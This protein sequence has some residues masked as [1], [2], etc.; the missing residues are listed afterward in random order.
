M[1]FSI[2]DR[3]DQKIRKANQWQKANPELSWAN[4]EHKTAEPKIYIPKEMLNSVAYRGL[5]RAA[6]LLLQDFLGKRI[7]KQI[8]KKK[9]IA[10]NNGNIIFPVR[11]AIKMGY[12]SKQFRNGLDELQSKGFLDITHIGKGGRKPLKGNADC[13]KYFIDERWRQFGTPEFKPARKPRQKDTRKNRGWALLMGDPET[14]KEILARRKKQK[15]V[16][17][18]T[19][20]KGFTYVPSDTS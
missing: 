12:S 15:P 2:A 13:S 10:E 6:M 16:S 8:S 7:M 4:P 14:K 20:V 1:G 19:Q 3:V 5:S 17:Q 11:E 18:K 9:W